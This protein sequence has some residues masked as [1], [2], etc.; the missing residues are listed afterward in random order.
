MENKFNKKETFNMH[1]LAKELITQTKQESDI[2]AIKITGND[3]DYIFTLTRNTRNNGKGEHGKNRLSMKDYCKEQSISH[4]CIYKILTKQ[5][6]IEEKSPN[7]LVLL[8][9]GF[10]LIHKN[11]L[12]DYDND[13]I[14]FP[15]FT[16]I[17]GSLY[18]DDT[19]EYF[20]DFL[21]LIEKDE[22]FKECP[23]YNTKLKS[24]KSTLPRYEQEFLSKYL[25]EEGVKNVKN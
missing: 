10:I 6:L 20:Q 24:R 9:D 3:T 11:Y 17:E 8:Y 25:E 16:S 14:F 18:V 22:M 2:E 21:D 23:E 13:N 15:I 5:R 19:H 12:A 7:N 4:R 1:S